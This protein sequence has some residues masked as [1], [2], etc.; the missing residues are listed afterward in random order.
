MCLVIFDTNPLLLCHLKEKVYLV[1][2][3]GPA[4]MACGTRS[5]ILSLATAQ[6]ED[7]ARSFELQGCLSRIPPPLEFPVI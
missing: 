1:T 5:G 2:I 7:D 4:A 3:I 6:F